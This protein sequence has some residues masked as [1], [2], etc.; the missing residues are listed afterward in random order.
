MVLEVTSCFIQYSV[1]M[2]LVF[3]PYDY[4][5]VVL[6]TSLRNKLYLLNKILKTSD[7]HF[8]SLVHRLQCIIQFLRFGLARS[9]SSFNAYTFGE[10]YLITLSAFKQDCN[11]IIF[12]VISLS[13]FVSIYEYLCY[14]QIRNKSKP[15]IDFSRDFVNSTEIFRLIFCQCS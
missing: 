6:E 7:F 13:R 12:I 14:Y 3:Y 4:H 9:K 1:W 10:N 8:S 2:F 5:Y 15:L 11:S